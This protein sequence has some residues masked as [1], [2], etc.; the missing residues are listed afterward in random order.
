MWDDQRGWASSETRQGCG[1]AT[2]V[3]RGLSASFAVSPQV[4]GGDGAGISFFYQGT[5]PTHEG[6]ALAT[7]PFPPATSL[8]PIYHM[9]L[10]VSTFKT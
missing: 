4:E 2:S 9:N 10:G 6:R 8:T 7:S 1:G 5:N 3:W